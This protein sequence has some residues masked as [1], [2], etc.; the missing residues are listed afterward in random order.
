VDSNRWRGRES[1]RTPPD[2]SELSLPTSRALVASEREMRGD[3]RAGP[4]DFGAGDASAC[5]GRLARDH[6]TSSHR[7]T[8][9]DLFLAIGCTAI[10]IEAEVRSGCGNTPGAFKVTVYDF[11]LQGIKQP[12]C[13]RIHEQAFLRKSDSAF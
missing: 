12:A 5:F 10:L 6:G 1:A 2:P 7:G 13:H 8:D 9:T 3:R 4:L 11:N